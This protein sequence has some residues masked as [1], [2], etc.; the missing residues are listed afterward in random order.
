LS[1]LQV[2][3]AQQFRFKPEAVDDRNSGERWSSENM[4]VESREA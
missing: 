1:V 4:A 3:Q 2:L